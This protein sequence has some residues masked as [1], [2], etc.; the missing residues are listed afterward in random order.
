[1]SIV[2]VLGAGSIGG[3][4]AY[5]LAE[6]NRFREVRLIDESAGVAEGKALDI[7]QA[8]AIEQFG[9]RLT[10]STDVRDAFGAR[11]VV[12]AD[13]FAVGDV[14]DPEH[15][16]VTLRGLA[17]RDPTSSFVCAVPEDIPVVERAVRDAL[18]PWTRVIGSA[19]VALTAAIRALVALELDGSPADVALPLLGV[20][21]S[22]IIVPWSQVTLGGAAVDRLL[23]PTELRRLERRLQRLWPPGPYGLASAAARVVEALAYGSRRLFCCCAAVS[24]DFGARRQ[25]MVVPLR[26]GPA[27]NVRTAVPSLSPQERVRVMN[28]LE[29]RV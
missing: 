14:H 12:L 8:G 22:H 25:A 1:M 9:A 11:V 29:R 15:T 28:A 21:P 18:L 17:E 27:G 26:F 3:A 10:C 6:R 5:K 2:A 20:P 7:Q 19:P 16:L 24:G 4:T 13:R 23:G